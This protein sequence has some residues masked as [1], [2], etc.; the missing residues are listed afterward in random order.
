[1]GGPCTD[2]RRAGSGEPLVLIHGIGSSWRAWR[3]VLEPL[4]ARY[5]VLSVSLPGYGKS[6]PLDVEPTVP[7]L[8]DA[9]EAELDAAGFDTAHLV[10]N[11]LG[12]WIAADLARR[13]RARTVVA[14]SP[15]GL[16]TEKELLYASRSLRASYASSRAMDPFADRLTRSALMRT[17]LFAQVAARGWR[18]SPEEAA[19]MIRTLA[20][21][22]S[23]LDTMDWIVRNRAMPE[24]LPA[25]RCPFRV[26]WGT[27]DFLLPLRQ[28]R[29]WARLVPGAELQELPRLGH[30]AMLDD[31]EAIV[32]S[33]L[34]V[35]TRSAEP[36]PEPAEVRA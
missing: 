22:P 34:E 3:P 27:W 15:A 4:E 11:S 24:G 32:E 18:A 12:G 29:R 8:V 2:R 36:A 1:V 6:P 28:A 33:I 7:A 13:G 5:D 14:S 16:W 17:L 31:P 9:L 10:G 25:I 26:V 30:V 21:S 23:F 35:T 20:R 19:D